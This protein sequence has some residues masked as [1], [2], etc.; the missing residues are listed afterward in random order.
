MFSNKCVK[1]DYDVW[2]LERDEMID[3][4]ILMFDNLGLLEEFDIPI[5]KLR[6]FAKEIQR[7]YHNNPY[8]NFRHA[9]D[10]MQMC[11]TFLVESKAKVYLT[12]QDKLVLLIAAL[13]HDVD[14]PGILH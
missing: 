8:H 14:H 12:K 11:Y 13:C 6:N 1:W 5:D 3:G 4:V 9:F 2:A 10:V 7:N